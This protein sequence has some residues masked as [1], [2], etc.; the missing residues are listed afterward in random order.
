M[1]IYTFK[2]SKR[3]IVAA[4]LVVAVILAAV[5][6]LVP[7]RQESQAAST[8]QPGLKVKT[9]ADCVAYAATLGYQVQPQAGDTRKVTIP[10]EFDDIYNKYNEIQKDCGF[11]L[12]QFCGKGV[13]LYTFTVTNY[14]GQ[15]GVLLDLL[16]YKNKVI[17][18]AVYTAAIDGFMHGLMSN[19]SV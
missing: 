13:T 19:P 4:V 8:P 12:S 11:D 7:S 15:D 2:L 17:G 16:V 3:K 9:E 14:S 1:N 5:I 10:K 6:L 18:G